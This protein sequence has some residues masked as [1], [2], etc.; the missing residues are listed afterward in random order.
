MRRIVEPEWLDELPA[1]DVRAQGSRHDLR[2]LNSI[3]GHANLLGKALASAVND[4]SPKR[5]VELGAG[6]GTLLLALAKKFS[7][8]WPDVEIFL[9]DR[10]DTVSPETRAAFASLGWR[11]EMVKADVMNWLEISIDKPADIILAN[12][13]LH[14][15][16]P[17]QLKELLALVA[18]KT[19]IFIACE[20]ERNFIPLA[21]S[22]MVGVIGCNAVTRN[23]APASV[24]AGFAGRE[25]SALWSASPK[26]RLQETRA[27]VF[28]HLFLAKHV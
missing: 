1:G 19:R 12:L 25:I 7:Q 6:D 21:L 26:W 20:P 11:L 13:F 28:S 14:H 17:L 15:F 4:A 24:R 23:D 16:Q 10:I 2:R 27:S 3:M 22:R 9:V 18:N 8:G 5:I